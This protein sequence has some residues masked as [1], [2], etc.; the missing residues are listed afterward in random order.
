MICGCRRRDSAVFTGGAR[1]QKRIETVM[2]HLTKKALPIAICAMA[3]G[4][5][6]S[7]SAQTSR[8]RMDIPFPFLAGN[9]VL[10]AGVYIVT[11]DEQLRRVLI[12]PRNGNPI[13]PLLF[14]LATTERNQ[15]AAAD[16]TLRFQKYGDRCVLRA[17]FQPGSTDGHVLVMSKT[18]REWAALAEPGE[19]ATVNSLR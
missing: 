18:E 8:T 6:A 1:R 16:A 7:A 14:S 5:A 12:E 11:V 2:N 3:F 9:D 15:S 10:P 19:I 13:R 4:L 17:V